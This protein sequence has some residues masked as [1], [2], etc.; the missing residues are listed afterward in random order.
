MCVYLTLCSLFGESYGFHRIV[1]SRL[2]RKES[3]S[4]L[5]S[6]SKC[7]GRSSKLLLHVVRNFSWPSKFYQ[8]CRKRGVSYPTQYIYLLLLSKIKHRNYKII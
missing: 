8:L 6:R 2:Y 3:I 1:E 7:L 5:L 4:T